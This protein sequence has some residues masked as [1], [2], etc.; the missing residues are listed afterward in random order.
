MAGQSPSVSVEMTSSVED[1]NYKSFQTYSNSN[2]SGSGGK[3]SKISEKKKNKN[4]F[5]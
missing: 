1:T 2:D 3:T 5:H 4:K